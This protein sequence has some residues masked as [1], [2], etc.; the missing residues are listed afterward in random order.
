MRGVA[1][2]EPVVTEGQL[3]LSPG[4]HVKAGGEGKEGQEGQEGKDEK[5]GKGGKPEGRGGGKSDEKK[6]KKPA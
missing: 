5:G 1:A 4:A 6:S 3:R 2:G